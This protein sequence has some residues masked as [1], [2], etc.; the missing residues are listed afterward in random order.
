M[1]ADE[2]NHMSS[3]EQLQYCPGRGWDR[4][5]KEPGFRAV[6]RH[7]LAAT[8]IIAAQYCHQEIKADRM[9][10]NQSAKRIPPF[11]A[12]TVQTWCTVMNLTIMFFLGKEYDSTNSVHNKK[13]VP[14]TVCS[15]GAPILPCFFVGESFSYLAGST[16]LTLG[17]RRYITISAP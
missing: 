14:G 7:T 17:S 16:S 6:H 13:L 2:A 11:H 10:W 3:F 12:N 4:T 8:D 9:Y 15:C 5:E 1:A